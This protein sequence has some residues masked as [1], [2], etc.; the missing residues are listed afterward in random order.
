MKKKSIFKLVLL[1]IMLIPVGVLAGGSNDD[2]I[3]YNVKCEYNLVA[4][5]PADY[6]VSLTTIWVYID[7]NNS[8]LYSKDGIVYYK[9][10]DI[11]H[12]LSDANLLEMRGNKLRNPDW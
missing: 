4:S 6:D 1:L 2:N 8:I 5:H 12:T 3:A 9:K 11:R 10:D 7:E